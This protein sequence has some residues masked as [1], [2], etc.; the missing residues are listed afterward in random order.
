[1]PNAFTD[2]SA[3]SLG[4]SLVQTAYDRLVEFALRSQ[5][6]FRTV[7][8]KKPAQQAMPGSSVVFQLYNDLARVTGTLTETVDPDSVALPSTSNVQVTLQEYGNVALVTRKLE[9]FSLS[10]VDPAVAN[11]I[12]YNLADSIDEFAQT[13]L[14]GGP[15]VIRESGGS[16]STSAAIG[17]ITPTDTFKSRDVRFAVAKLRANNV[18][19]RRG[20]LYWSAIH[21]EVSHDLRAETGAAAWRDPHVYS[22]PDA[23]WAGEIGQYEGAYFVETPRAFSSQE[24]ADADGAGAGTALTRVFRTYFAGQQALAEAVAEE[25][26]VVV[27]PVVDKLMRFR[28][29]G[30]YGV[31]GW[32]RY[33]DAALYRVETASSIRP[34]A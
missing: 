4:T 18:I 23:L 22:A 24:G 21:P 34:T 14:R 28:P 33:R 13:E 3:G 2:T 30:W 32:K 6:M 17:T 10:D 20:N 19:P 11:I 31:L 1:M 25:P 15:N 29:L 8:D 7:A 26:H 9:L 12:A 27:G 16:L 5:P